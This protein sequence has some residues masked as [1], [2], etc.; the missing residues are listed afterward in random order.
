MRV[1]LLERDF[2]VE[3]SWGMSSEGQWAR[4][5]RSA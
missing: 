5:T 3:F 2:L 4:A 1:L